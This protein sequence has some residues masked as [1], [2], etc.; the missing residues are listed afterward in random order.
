MYKKLRSHTYLGSV[1]PA[2]NTVEYSSV[3][4]FLE[5][6]RGLSRL[7]FFHFV[8]YRPAPVATMLLYFLV[9]PTILYC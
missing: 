9:S 7:P 6:K 2:R 1:H 3:R 4:G 5:V 8:L